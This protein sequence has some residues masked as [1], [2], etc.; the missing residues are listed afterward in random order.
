MGRG[1]DDGRGT[2][3]IVFIP[4]TRAL[5]NQFSCTFLFGAFRS[6][7][8]DPQ[9]QFLGPSARCVAALQLFRIFRLHHTSTLHFP[10][11]HLTAV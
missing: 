2:G 1:S 3:G 6:G 8:S 11:M 10:N 5:A 7:A 4:I 9:S